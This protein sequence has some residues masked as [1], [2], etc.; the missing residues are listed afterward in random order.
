MS[1][2]TQE[3]GKDFFYGI[4]AAIIGNFVVSSIVQYDNNVFANG[5]HFAILFWA[6]MFIVTSILFFYT[7]KIILKDYGF[8]ESTLKQFDRAIIICVL[9]GIIGIVYAIVH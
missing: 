5:S 4:F 6:F 3:R 2:T 9:F 7:C 1:K 8:Q